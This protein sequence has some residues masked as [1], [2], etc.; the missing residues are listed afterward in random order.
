MEQTNITDTSPLCKSKTDEYIKNYNQ[1]YYL[2]HK[3]ETVVCPYC[4]YSVVYYSWSRHSHTKRHLQNKERA[5]K[6]LFANL[7]PSLILKLQTP[8]NV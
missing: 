2:Q 7:T 5:E 4:Q 1:C 8:Q 6:G 3:T